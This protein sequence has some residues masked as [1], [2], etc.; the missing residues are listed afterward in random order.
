MICSSTSGISYVLRSLAT[1]NVV[2]LAALPVHAAETLGSLTARLPSMANALVIIDVEGIMASPLAR[3]QGWARR[4]E[5]AYVERPVYLPPEARKL[6]LGASLQPTEDFASAWSAAVM[7]LLEP[8]SVRSI[9]RS[10]GGFLDEVNGV[11]VAVTPHDAGFLELGDSLLGV[12][13]PADRQFI[14]RWVASHRDSSPAALSSYLQSAV[15][16]VNDRVQV[17]LAIDL[18]D[19]LGPHQIEAGLADAAWLESSSADK[20]AIAETLAKLQGVTLRLAIGERCQGRLQIDFDADVAPLEK[21]ARPLIAQALGH[22]GMSTTEIAEWRISFAP[23]SI[24]LEG[25]LSADAQ[26]RV[27]SVIEL[28]Q[29]ALQTDEAAPG[30]AAETN[31]SEVRDRSMAYFRSTQVLL[32]DLRRGLKDTKATSA[33]MERYAKR[34]DQLP[35][36]NVDE[37]LLDYGDKL[38]ETLRIMAL[39]KRQAGIQ[40][41]V[42]ATEGGSYYDG[43]DYGSDA[44][45]RAADRSQARKEEMAVASDVRVQGWKLIDDATADIRRTLTQK[46][47]VE[48]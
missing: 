38:A 16:L 22:L 20:Q 7:D 37:L 39:S 23:R 34:V 3:E 10:E 44:Y 6:V 26:R 24:R 41:G 47:G 46:Y 36:L 29:V 13:F 42:R 9:A 45:S 32:D 18:T 8:V 25:E 40:Y 35:V 21:T 28:P 14:S 15:E 31:E 43:Y 19:V 17:L 27:F 5:T 33:W 30:D 1:L 11:R 48:F 2:L 4:L 12:V